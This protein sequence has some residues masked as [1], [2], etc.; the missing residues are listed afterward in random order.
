[1]VTG[2]ATDTAGTA[3]STSMTVSIDKTKPT[4]VV[5]SPVDGATFSSSTVTITGTVADNL[6]DI[7]WVRCNGQPANIDGRRRGRPR[8]TV[9][10]IL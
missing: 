6:S 7:A 1:M 3:V 5:S 9:G 2:T 8:H 4:L 10:H